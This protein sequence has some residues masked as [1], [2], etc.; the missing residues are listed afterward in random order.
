MAA[1]TP[2]QAI[3]TAPDAT[4]SFQFTIPP[5]SSQDPFAAK[6]AH[7]EALRSEVP[8]LQDEINV[9]LT[10]KMEEDKKA[11][12]QLSE[13]EAKEEENYGEEVVEDDA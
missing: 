3:Y 12:G 5:A 6:Q 13:K 10:A 9:Y 1:N 7:L 4:K 8:K 2:L 11:Q